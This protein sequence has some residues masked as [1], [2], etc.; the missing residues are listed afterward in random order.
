MD[1]TNKDENVFEKIKN[2]FEINENI[3]NISNK[4][5][6]DNRNISENNNE[7]YNNA[8]KLNPESEKKI[9]EIKNEKA[10]INISFI[11]SN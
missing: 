3:N 9:N 2:G 6:N 7:L 10:E 8:K 5:D 11:S 1:D 4:D